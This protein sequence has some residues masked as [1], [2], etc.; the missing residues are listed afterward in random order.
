M[1]NLD[2]QLADLQAGLDGA[3][4]GDKTQ[5]CVEKNKQMKKYY[6]EIHL[7]T[8]YQLT[9]TPVLDDDAGS[10]DGSAEDNEFIGKSDE[11]ML[12]GSGND[13]LE[14]YN[15]YEGEGKSRLI[16]KDEDDHIV[17]E[18]DDIY[19]T[20]PKFY[21]LGYA[22]GDNRIRFYDYGTLT[23]Y[24]DDAGPDLQLYGC[25]D[26]NDYD[27]WSK[28]KAKELEVSYDFEAQRT[29][30]SEIK[31]HRYHLLG[32]Y[33][34]SDT[35]V[36]FSEFET[37]SF[38]PGKLAFVEPLRV[39]ACIQSFMGEIHEFSLNID[40]LAYDDRVIGV[41]EH[42]FSYRRIDALELMDGEDSIRYLKDLS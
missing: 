7:E 6:A 13:D 34:E 23:Y 3:L 10:L 22:D 37:D 38:D 9:Y 31:K 18:K 20:M 26:K 24:S 14:I 35:I 2:K 1:D 33:K 11:L 25:K 41:E 29:H 27:D 19:F 17:Y 28:K 5:E 39:D 40:S 30:E 8:G 4:G 36:R 21:Y 15:M 42:D 32:L 16:I 12:G